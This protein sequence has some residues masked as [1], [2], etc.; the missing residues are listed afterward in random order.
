M[1]NTT[2]GSQ[3]FSATTPVVSAPSASISSSRAPLALRRS[4]VAPEVVESGLVR[5]TQ[6]AADSIPFHWV[7]CLAFALS[8]SLPMWA[9]IVYGVWAVAK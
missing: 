2:R 9:V 3:T 1:S 5:Q 7:R 4:P 6:C 8:L